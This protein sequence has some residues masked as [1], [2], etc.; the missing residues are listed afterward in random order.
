[1]IIPEMVEARKRSIEGRLSRSVPE[2]TSQPVFSPTSIRY[3]LAERTQAIHYGGIGL[4][5]K[6]ASESGLIEALDNNLSLLKIHM[7]YHA[8]DHVLNI[9]YNALCEGRC[10]EDIELRR[11]DRH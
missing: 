5:H 3:E 8:S 7:P 9:A 10:L 6:L 1:M 2:D 11:N 4:I